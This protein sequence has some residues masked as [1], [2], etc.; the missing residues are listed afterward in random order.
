MPAAAVEGL[1][2]PYSSHQSTTSSV[3]SLGIMMLTFVFTVCRPK[4]KVFTGVLFGRSSRI[5]SRVPYQSAPLGQ[6]VAH[7][8]FLPALVRS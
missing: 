3:L 4:R 8:G 6:T 1:R 5:F 2:S 7:I